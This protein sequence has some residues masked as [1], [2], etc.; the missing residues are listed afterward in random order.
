VARVASSSLVCQ[1]GRLGAE[2]A[3]QSDA[4]DGDPQ[5]R[6]RIE[7][8]LVG[9]LIG[10][11]AGGPIEFRPPDGIVDRMPAC[12]TWRD[13]RRLLPD[14]LQRLS[15]SFQLFSYAELRPEP[16]PY[17]QWTPSAAAGTVTDD[18]RHKMILLNALRE[19]R[20]EGRLPIDASDLAAAYLQFPLSAPIAKRPEYAELCRKSGLEFNRAA[21]WVLGQRDSDQAAPPERLWGGLDTC[22]GQ[23]A[24]LPLAAIYAGRPRQAYQAAYQLGFVDNGPGKD[25]NAALVAGLA[26]ALSAPALSATSAAST[27]DERRGGWQSV[28]A[29]MNRT[30]PY[31][32]ADVPWV[33]RPITRWLQFASDAVHRAEGQPKRLYRL[34]EEEAEVRYFWEAHFVVA[35]GF[36]MI[37]FCDYEPL[38]ALHL[39]LDF[40]HDTDSVAQLMGAF[41]GALHGPDVF[42]VAMRQKVVKR[43][44]DDYDQSLTEWVELLLTLR[45]MSKVKEIVRLR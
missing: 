39:L 43:L 25:I 34:L 9:S 10:D 30:D 11:A 4:A 14:D 33:A 45:A 26:F 17:A 6:R 27:L 31:Q 13:G 35:L 44:A 5:L 19:A 36:A 28:T 29:T 1:A 20:S 12:R 8:M 15:E 2:Q 32:Y 38:A 23:M 21:R 24:L 37:E 16:G 42:P 22:C 18:S 3:S 40:G 41:I 7:G